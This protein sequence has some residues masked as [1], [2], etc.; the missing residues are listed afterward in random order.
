MVVTPTR[1]YPLPTLLFL[2]LWLDT[3][4]GKDHSYTLGGLR[5]LKFC[6]HLCLLSLFHWPRYNVEADGQP[7]V[8]RSLRTGRHRFAWSLIATERIDKLAINWSRVFL[9]FTPS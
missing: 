8:S 6:K 3:V 5:G 7:Q 9:E 4:L 2:A 1:T